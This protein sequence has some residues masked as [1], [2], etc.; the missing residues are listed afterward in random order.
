[1]TTTRYFLARFAQAFGIERRQQRM[2]EAASEMHLLRE[3]EAHLGQAVWEKTENIESVSVE[4][5]NLRKLIKE[6]AAVSEKLVECE[7]RLTQAHAERAE[8]LNAV[9][10]SLQDLVDRRVAILAELEELARQRDAVVERA[11]SVRRSY[12]GMKMKLEVLERESGSAG[13]EATEVAKA[14]ARLDELK[15]QFAQLKGERG[16][17][18]K[19]IEAGDARIDALDAEIDKKK[20]KRRSEASQAFQMIGD[21]NKDISALRA[22]LGLLETRMRQLFAEI[23]RHVSRHAFHDPAC[24]AAAKE[25]SGLVEVMR[26]LRRSIAFNHRLGNRD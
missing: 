11:R 24:A 1:M 22:E 5:W 7:E 16:E 25:K 9:P 18:G 3:A 19:Q 8:L 6:H 2:G 17:V 12:D 21:A 10:E 14:K 15:E 13:M 23:G 26:A 20:Q 4:Y